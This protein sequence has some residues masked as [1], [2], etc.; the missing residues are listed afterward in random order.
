MDSAAQLRAPGPRPDRHEAH[1]R[2][3]RVLHNHA[4]IHQFQVGAPGV[5]GEKALNIK[6][7]SEKKNFDHKELNIKTRTSR[8]LRFPIDVF[9]N[10]VARNI[11]KVL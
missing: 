6:R 10:L 4:G 5:K 2:L 1:V 11:K 9:W 3:R 8:S 7:N